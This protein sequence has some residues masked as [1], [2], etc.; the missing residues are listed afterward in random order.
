MAAARTSAPAP[1]GLLL[2]VRALLTT[3]P[4]QLVGARGF[5]SLTLLRVEAHTRT[6]ACAK[7]GQATQLLDSAFRPDC[8][9]A[10]PEGERSRRNNEDFAELDERRFVRGLLPIRLE[11]REEFRF[12]IWL[13]V[14]AD[15]FDD[16]LVSWNDDVRYPRWQFVATIANAIPPWGQAGTRGI[17]AACGPGIVIARA[18][19]AAP[20][21]VVTPTANASALFEAGAGRV[22]LVCGG[23]APGVHLIHV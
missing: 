22:A 1:S 14:T 5:S 4:C 16:V 2:R 8:G 12:G 23:L 21:P 3:C 6:C 11:D 15:V 13:E 19:R 18:D 9:W 17:A 20:G 7:C 10:Q